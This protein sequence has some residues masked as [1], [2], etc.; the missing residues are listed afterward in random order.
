LFEAISKQSKLAS[1]KKF[2]KDLICSPFMSKHHSKPQT[3]VLW[4][5]FHYRES[6]QYQV[7]IYSI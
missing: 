2:S 4:D 3:H 1:I 6:R 5:Y 7:K